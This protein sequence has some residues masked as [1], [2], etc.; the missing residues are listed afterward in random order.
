MTVLTSISTM[1]DE[2]RLNYPSMD[3]E[4]ECARKILW[5]CSD[6]QNFSRTGKCTAKIASRRKMTK[7]FYKTVYVCW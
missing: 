2:Q 6:V 1:E 3:A 5:K 7:K 4:L